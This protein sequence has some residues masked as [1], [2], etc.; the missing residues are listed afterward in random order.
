MNSPCNPT[1]AVYSKEELTALADILRE[2]PQIQILS[3]DIYEHIRFT[4]EPFVTFANVAP[5]L[6]DRILTMNGVSKTYVMTGFRL[7][8]AAGNQTLIKAMN[9]INSQT[10]TSAIYHQP[11]GGSGGISRRLRFFAVSI[12]KFS[13]IGAIYC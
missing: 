1:G 2:F 13:N 9:M 4:D 7:G 3:D 8:Y 11:M 6:Q 12:K 5:D 10:T